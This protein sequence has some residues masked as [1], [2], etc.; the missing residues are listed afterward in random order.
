MGNNQFVVHTS[1]EIYSEKEKVIHF[2]L[3]NQN[4]HITYEYD[5]AFL[6]LALFLSKPHTVQ[7]TVEELQKQHFHVNEEEVKQAIFLLFSDSILKIV[8][9]DN[10]AATMS[11]IYNRQLDFFEEFTDGQ[12]SATQFQQRL[13]DAKVVILG[14]GGIGSWIAYSLVQSGV[15]QLTL[16]D[17]DRVEESNLTRQAGY[18]VQD[19]G[20]LKV[21]ALADFLQ[22]INPTISLQTHAIHCKETTDFISICEGK[23]LIISCMDEPNSVIPGRWIHQVGHTL[24]I[25]HMISGG[26][27][28]HLGLIGPTIIPG[29]S[30]CYEC[31]VKAIEEEYR[32]WK[33]LKPAGKVGTIGALSAVIANLHAFEAIRVL[34]HISEPAMLNKKGEFDFLHNQFVLREYKAQQNCPYCRKKGD[35]N[36]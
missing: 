25:P 21:D 32:D 8:N 18:R 35:E 6:Q 33:L 23:D 13:H 14:L 26:Y 2:L 22:Q 12:K 10:N 24:H 20:R 11:T 17:G 9:S 19:I 3:G 27:R 15:R 34:T 4:R 28:G 5:P 36:E 30:V 1:V 16:V 31:I 29:K 7:E